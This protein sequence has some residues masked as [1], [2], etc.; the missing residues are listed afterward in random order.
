MTAAVQDRGTVRTSP[1]ALRLRRP[2]WRDPRLLAGVVLLALSVALGSWAVRTAGRTVD[3][4]AVTG[5]IVPGQ[6]LDGQL[7]VRQVRVPDPD[8]YLTPA[9]DVDGLVA[10][11]TV[12]AGELVPRSAVATEQELGVRPVAVE[13]RGAL[14]SAVVGGSHVDLWFVPEPDA[15]DAAAAPRELVSGV[16]VAEIEEARGGLSIGTGTTVHVLVPVEALADV[17]TALAADGSV[18]VVHVPGGRP[19]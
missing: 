18:E 14:P 11:R 16:T 3:V 15:D 5:T 1:P 7:Q 19:S 2:G 13:P 4:L 8:L 12:G 10:V 17:L 9:D 6:T